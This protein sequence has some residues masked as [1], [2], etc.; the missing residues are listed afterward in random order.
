MQMNL[1]ELVIVFA[2]VTVF[3]VAIQFFGIDFFLILVAFYVGWLICNMFY[4]QGAED[5]ARA[6]RARR[7][8]E[9]GNE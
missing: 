3:G 4:R 2:L 7:A 9:C 8:T 5:Q 6:E 1:L